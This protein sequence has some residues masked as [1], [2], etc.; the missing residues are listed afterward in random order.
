MKFLQGPMVWYYPERMDIFS[1]AE[2]L[3]AQ[4]GHHLQT[5]ALSWKYAWIQKLFGWTTAKRAQVVYNQSK[6][7]LMQSID[8]ML[9][10]LSP[11][12]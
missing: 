11:S 9:F 3:A 6:T 4:M 5:P 8:L 1:E 7:R 12:S 10:R 2:K